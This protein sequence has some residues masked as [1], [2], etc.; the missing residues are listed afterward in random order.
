MA[1]IGLL[2]LATRTPAQE[3]TQVPAQAAEPGAPMS[4]AAAVAA[5]HMEMSPHAVATAADSA[6]AASIARTLRAALLPFRDTSA[7][8]AAGYRMFAP[9]LKNQKVYH[10]TSSWRGVEEAFRFDATKPTSLL[11]TKGMDGTFSLVG[12]MYTA[13]KRF[14]PGQLDARVPL[15]IG[16][17]HK[18][19]NWCIP[20]RGASQR[21]L[22]R[23]NGEP[24]F[25][26]DSP[27]ATRD[28]CDVVGGTFHDTLFGWM[29]HAYVFAGDDPAS[30]WGDEHAGHDMHAGMKMAGM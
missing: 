18:H 8:V 21:W 15:G 27:I 14:S 10:F 5:L 4:R 26:P 23:R 19:V 25:G 9:Q 7:A 17:W 28:A 16:H 20:K 30:I 22:E 29:I 11:Y 24:V 3:R 2:V 6:R 13:P 1:V 12:A